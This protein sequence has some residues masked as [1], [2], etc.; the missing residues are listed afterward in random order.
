MH[1]NW[2]TPCWQVKEEKVI[3]ILA[4]R[5]WST[6]LYCCLQDNTWNYSRSWSNQLP[7]QLNMQ[8][9]DNLKSAAFWDMVPCSHV[10]E[11]WCFRGTY[12]LCLQGRSIWCTEMLS[13]GGPMGKEGTWKDKVKHLRAKDDDKK[14]FHEDSQFLFLASFILKCLALPL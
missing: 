5:W 14:R 4:L 13:V 11:Y 9:T 10:Y 8:Q 3:L 12:S 1:T 2:Y 6:T 7:A